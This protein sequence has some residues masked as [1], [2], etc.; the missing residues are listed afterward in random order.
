MTQTFRN[1]V[2]HSTF[3]HFKLLEY[4]QSIELEGMDEP[5]RQHVEYNSNLLQLKTLIDQRLTGVAISHWLIAIQVFCLWPLSVAQ[6]HADK[7]HMRLEVALFH[8]LTFIILWK[9]LLA[10]RLINMALVF[11]YQMYNSSSGNCLSAC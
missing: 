9:V 10:L 6:V 2:Q 1:I 11:Y 3:K 4:Y 8:P 5:S 7:V